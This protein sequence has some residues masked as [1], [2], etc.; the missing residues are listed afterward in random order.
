MIPILTTPI[1]VA[2]LL[3]LFTG[4]AAE[5]QTG[6]VTGRVTDARSGAPLGGV[7]ILVVGPSLSARS[8]SDGRFLIP[9]VPGG[10]VTVRAR[11]VGYAPAQRDITVTA[12]GPVVLELALESRPFDLDEIVVTGA[13]AVTRQREVGHAVTRIDPPQVSPPPP[14]ISNLLQAAATGVEVT[15]GS[16]EAGQGKHIRL[17]GNRSM[18]LSNQ[19]L[20]YVDGIR[21]MDGAFPSDVFERPDVQAPGGAN[22]TST[23]LDM[24]SVGDI[25][26]IEIVKGPA[27][28]TLFGTG[29]ANG[30]IQIFTRRGR[31]GP[32]TWTADIVQGT[33]W[34]RPFG[35][36]G[37]DYLHLEHFLRDSWWGGG[38]EGGAESDPCVTDDPRWRGANSSTEGGCRWP[39]SQWYQTYRLAVDGGTDRISYFA[40]GTYQNDTYALPLDRLERYG[41]R[42]NLV[43]APSP[44]IDIQAQVAHTGMTTTNTVSGNDREGILLSTM[45]RP[46]NYINSGDPR[47]IAGLLGNRS[48]QEIGRFTSGVTT[49]FAQSATLSH[50]LT[51]GYDRSGQDLRSQRE[52]GRI[53]EEGGLTTRA[54]DRRLGTVDYVA[55]RGFS[56]RPD[57]RSTLSLGGQLVHDEVESVVATTEE[58]TSDEGLE[59]FSRSAGSTANVGLWAQNVLDIGNRWFLTLGLRMDRHR[60]RGRTSVGI[61]PMVSGAW[62]VSDE[63]FWPEPLGTLRVRAAYGR[64]SSAAG[65]FEQAVTWGAGGGPLDPEATRLLEPERISEWEVG[66]DGATLG[67]R[68]AVSFSAYNQETSDA[69]VSMTDY[70]GPPPFRS[71]LQNVGLLRNRGIELQLDLA[72]VNRARWG[73]DLGVA[74]TTNHSKVLDLGGAEPSRDQDAALLVG[75]PAPVS[76]GYRVADPDAIN[77][78]WSRDRYILGPDSMPALLPLGPHLPTHVVAPSLSFRLPGGVTL[79]ARGEYRGGN[80]R[81][82]SPV[83]VGRNGITSPLCHPWYVDRDPLRGLKLRPDTPDLWQERCSSTGA[84]DYWY[85]ADYFRLRHVTAVVPIGF[86]LPGAVEGSTLSITL[87]NAYTWYREVP[88]WDLEVPSN[89]GANED[90]LGSSERVPAPTT[91]TFGVRVRF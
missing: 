12:G 81:N 61:D 35:T 87:G 49:T 21:M 28:S 19:P 55:T 45:R 80:I 26:R 75:H 70:E 3:V 15:G 72:V 83:E 63:G 31:P 74:L 57:V 90:R 13:A 53:S 39:G 68:L 30:V 18:A 37:V 48:R 62:V 58:G 50:R 84:E 36:N 56:V 25:D 2:L 20:I 66:L 86:M 47:V 16:G 33:G 9:D 54:W 27:A 88:W 14:T 32:A 29:S 69:L 65:P 17:R 38:Y 77:G 42:V 71:E 51:V 60:V 79:D 34:V 6:S 76:Y 67:E 52:Q 24:V 43:A 46:A 59:E 23:P 41:L 7:E 40:S 82:V 4:T 10:R 89:G 44:R 64:S 11:Q 91:L 73:V 5:A 1:G 85:D 78:P 22:I 8:R